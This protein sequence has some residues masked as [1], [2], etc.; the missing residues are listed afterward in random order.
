MGAF[1]ASQAD[2]EICNNLTTR[3]SDR[4]KPGDPR[5]RTYIQQLRD[6]N[7]REPLFDTSHSLPRVAYRLAVSVTGGPP[8]PANKTSRLRWTFLL[9]RGLPQA[10]KA[11]IRKVLKAVL[12]PNSAIAYATFATRHIPTRSQT[13]ELFPENDG[14]PVLSQDANGKTYCQLILDCHTDAPLPDPAPGT[15]PDPPTADPGETPISALK[16]KKKI[17]KKYAAKKTSKRKPAKKRRAKAK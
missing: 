16:R 17:A 4:P 9:R 6:H 12:K 15:E 3:F 13:F 11:A 1:I 7:G 14:T 5:H 10:T 8:V 2:L